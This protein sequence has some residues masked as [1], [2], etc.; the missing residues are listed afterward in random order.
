MNEHTTVAVPH[1][2]PCAMLVNY[3][4]TIHLSPSFKAEKKYLLLSSRRLYIHEV[5]WAI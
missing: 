4:I 5:H 2:D 1:G 3:Q